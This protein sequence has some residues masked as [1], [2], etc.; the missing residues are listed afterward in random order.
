MDVPA[1]KQTVLADLAL[2]HECF[3]LGVPGKF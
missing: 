3:V 2:E 1:H